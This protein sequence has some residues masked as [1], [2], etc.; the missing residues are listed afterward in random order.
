ML[1]RRVLLAAAL[2]IGCTA[3]AAWSQNYPDRPIRLIVPQAAG[4]ATDVMIRLVTPRW[5]ELLGQ[6]IVIDDRPG[7]GAV[8]GT[9]AVAK[10]APDGYTLLLGGSQ[11]HAINRSLYSR[12]SYDP[13]AD[14]TPIGRMATQ[15]MLLVT[16]SSM[17]VKTVADLLA[18]AKSG[19]RRATYASSGNGSSAHLSGS[20]FSSEAK[21][22]AQHV[23]YKAIGQGFTELLNGDV[24][25]MFYPYAP[26]RG[27]IQAGKLTVLAA[28][29]EKRV[30]YLP[31]VPTMGEAG[32]P[33]VTLSPWFAVYAP[34]GTPRRIVDTLYASMEKALTDPAVV[35]RLAAIG[36][37]VWLAGPDETAKFN[38]SE[39][40]RYRKVVEDSGAK[41]E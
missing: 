8:I 37:D 11:T 18:Y 29:S 7:A 41:A 22:N 31:N 38:Q 2:A 5:S 21:L 17:P 32:F 19:N 39:I 12:L 16:T 33:S 4:S 6:Q 20:L 34:A 25:M 35:S 28:A 40:V 27:F 10:A 26:L 14:F 23:P 9:D 15:A 3:T 13:I 24:T 36:T 1:I 30:S